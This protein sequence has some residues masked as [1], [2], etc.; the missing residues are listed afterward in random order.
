MESK[1]TSIANLLKE[2]DREI[3]IRKRYESMD[4]SLAHLFVWLSILASFS[5]S[6]FIASKSEVDKFLLAI[7]AGIPGVI[8]VIDRSF[9]FAKRSAWGGM[10]RLELEELKDKILLTDID[11]Y[12]AS[13]EFRQLKR[14]NS[15]SFLRI[16]FFTPKKDEIQRT[17]LNNPDL[18]DTVR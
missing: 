10:Y 12:E 7:I 9:D 6:I 14:K 4:F 11:P 13:K 8:V 3:K 2:I 1:E 17:D 16:G 15:S 5:A 18:N